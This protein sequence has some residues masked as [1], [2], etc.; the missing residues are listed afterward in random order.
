MYWNGR[1]E[2]AYGRGLQGVRENVF[3]T[4]KSAGRTADDAR[5]V[6]ETSLRLLKTDYVATSGRCTTSG[7]W[8][9]WRPS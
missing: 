6:L 3:L 2:E 7:R 1:S 8:M 9:P 4:S 5:K